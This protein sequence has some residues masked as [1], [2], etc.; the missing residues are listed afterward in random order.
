MTWRSK[1]HVIAIFNAEVEYRA[2]SHTASEMLWVQSLLREMRVE[3]LAPMEMYCDNKAAMFIASNT[4]FH[5]RTKHIEVD[6]H[7]IRDMIM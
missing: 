4:V 7:F 5:E 3:A 1:K 2:M 6:C